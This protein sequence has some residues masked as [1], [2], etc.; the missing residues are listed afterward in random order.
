MP[1]PRSK[2]LPGLAILV[3]LGSFLLW[4]GRRAAHAPSDT[5]TSQ[6]P[7][8]AVEPATAEVQRP[9][10]APAEPI[11]TPAPG[12][13]TRPPADQPHGGQIQTE[14]GGKPG[15][16]TYPDGSTRQALNGVTANVAALWDAGRPFSPIVGTFLDRG[17]EWYRH[18]DGSLS[19]VNIVEINGVPQV[20]P[21]TTHPN[22][23]LP[24]QGVAS[25]TQPTP[26]K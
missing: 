9:A 25:P 19:T 18:A 3:G 15:W 16:I 13:D 10:T 17:W 21:V 23:M 14:R 11:A 22:E 26:K 2:L 1:A 12:E 20:C 4:A 7:A 8:P 5:Q 6:A 24:V